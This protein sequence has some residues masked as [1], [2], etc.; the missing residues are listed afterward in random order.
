MLC[1]MQQN[2]L[3]CKIGG[4]ILWRFPAELSCEHIYLSIQCFSWKHFNYI[5]EASVQSSSSS[6]PSLGTAVCV[7]SRQ[8]SISD[9]CA[10]PSNEICNY[11]SPPAHVSLC[12][13]LEQNGGRTRE[14]IYQQCAQPPWTPQGPFNTRFLTIYHNNTQRETVTHT[15]PPLT[16]CAASEQ[17]LNASVIDYTVTV[18][19]QRC[20][21]AYG[22]INTPE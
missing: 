1:Y 2:S 14:Q 20:N 4:V 9:K 12:M 3:M 17:S 13:T 10:T 11:V 18:R 6:S 16:L 8:L 5:L 22:S 15:P 7:Y 21:K 19:G